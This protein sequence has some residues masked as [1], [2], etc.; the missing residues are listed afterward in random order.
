MRILRVVALG[1]AAASMAACSGGDKPAATFEVGSPNPTSTVRSAASQVPASKL[2][3]P[4]PARMFAGTQSTIGQLARYCKGSA[5]AQ[6]GGAPD[7]YLT[8]P[9]GA[10]VVFSLGET[11]VEAVAEVRVRTGEQPGVVRLNPNTLMVFNH[12]LGRGKYL[13]DLVVRWRGSDARW[14]FG[15]SVT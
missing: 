14:R 6:A 2:K 7:A 10:F 3:P 4:P 13:V 1:L 8:A 12:G 15:L 11:P 9:T 5:C